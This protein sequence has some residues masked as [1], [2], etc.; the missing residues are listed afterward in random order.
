MIERYGIYWVNLDPVV[1]SEIAKTRP[2]VVV[3]DRHMNAALRTVV[4]CPL[5][6]R[7]HPHW[8]FRIPVHAGDQD[9]EVAVDQIRTVDVARLGQCIGLIDG[10][11]A[12][13]IRH[14]ITQMY[15]L[16]SV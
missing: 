5:T 9:G 14:V 6:T 10:T 1:G 16:L 4:V 12:A 7:R 2:A 8:P 11:A 13:E 3:S 15:G